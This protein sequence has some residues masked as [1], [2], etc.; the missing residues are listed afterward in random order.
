VIDTGI[1]ALG[2]TRDQAIAFVEKN[3]ML[4]HD[5]AVDEVDRC[6][7]APAQ[8]L[9]SKL[10]E[11]EILRLREEAQRRLGARFELRGFHNAVLGSGAVSLPVLREQIE[12][13]IKA[14]GR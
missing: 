11:R 14:G 4:T 10:G 8:A 1:H 12:A 3:A 13:W 2:W 5:D 7:T 6:I 9:A